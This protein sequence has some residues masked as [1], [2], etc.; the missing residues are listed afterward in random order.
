MPEMDGRALAR[1]IRRYRGERDLPLLL[2]TSIGR[3]A[4]A[5]TASE[6]TV[7]LTK[8]VKASQLYEALVRTLAAEPTPEPTAGKAAAESP[9]GTAALRLLLA[10]DNAFNRQLALALLR[11]LGYHADVVEN[12]REALDALERQ[13]Y[14]VVLMDV[15]MPELD[16][17][18]ATREIR[19]RFAPGEGPKIIAITA[20][21]M[22]SDR[23]DCL[24]AGMDDHLSKPIRIDELSRALARCR[25]VTEAHS[26]SAKDDSAARSDDAL[27]ETA[28]ETLTSSL[29]GEEGRAAVQELIDAFLEDAPTEIA[30]LRSA[31][32][33][34]DADE[35]RRLA[36]TLKSNAA[37]FGARTLSDLCRKLEALGRQRDLGGGPELLERVEAKWERVR[38]ALEAI[39]VGRTPR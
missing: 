20:N 33:R 34:G 24:A 5:R 12:G 17:L 7:Q 37:T 36:H 10:E 15:Q 39:R 35:T 14:D 18:E 8:P 3:L 27:D 23:E 30:M 31:I 22:E 1:E 32:E 2:L 16:G 11:K 9:S 4:E 29:G 21:A 19:G 26:G 13:A 25:A 6:F 28:L 38:E